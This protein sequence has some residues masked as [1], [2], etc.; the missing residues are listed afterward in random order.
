MPTS[1]IRRCSALS[2]SRPEGMPT[3]VTAYLGENSVTGGT[4]LR[5]PVFPHN[6][7]GSERT[8]QPWRARS[9]HEGD[10]TR[11]QPF[12]ANTKYNMGT[13]TSGTDLTTGSFAMGNNA[14]ALEH[15][16]LRRSPRLHSPAP[17]MISVHFGL[18]DDRRVVLAISFGYADDD[19]PANIYRTPRAPLD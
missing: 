18:P 12:H 5:I 16:L 6:E 10:C 11:S 19:H 15:S 8:A 13:V 2:D 4:R 1:S 7:Y 3:P 17:P 14:A 9:I